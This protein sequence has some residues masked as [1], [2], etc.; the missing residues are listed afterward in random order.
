MAVW[1]NKI[2]DL[3]SYIDAYGCPEVPQ[4]TSYSKKAL[5]L[6]GCGHSVM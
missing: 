3:G 6:E 1:N 5:V 4:G 2:I